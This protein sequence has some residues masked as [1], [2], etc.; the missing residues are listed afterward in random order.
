MPDA[1]DKNGDEHRNTLEDPEQ[2]LV[3]ECV[4]VHAFGEFDESVDTA[5]L[6]GAVST[7]RAIGAASVIE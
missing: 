1:E 4:A 3:S 2:P 5:D 7:L 6:A